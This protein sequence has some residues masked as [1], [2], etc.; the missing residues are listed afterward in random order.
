[1][2]KGVFCYA[3]ASLCIVS[4]M[5]SCDDD[6]DNKLAPGYSGKD[7]SGQV[8]L[9][10]DAE[11][12]KAVLNVSTDNAW[13]LYAGTAED[14]I[15]LSAPYLDGSGKGTFDVDADTKTRS[16]FLF[17]TSEGQG[18][19]A[20]KH[21]PMEGGYNFRD[22]GGIK[23]SEGRFVKWGKIFRTDEMNKLTDEDLAYL[24]ST[25][26]KTVVDF[27]TEAEKKGGMGGMIPEAYDKNPS[28]VE[29]TY[30]LPINAGN[31]FSDEVIGYIS[32]GATAEQLEP[33]MVRTYEEI[34]GVDEYVDMLKQFFTYVQNENCL[35]LSYHCS[36]GKDRTGVATML[37]LSALGVDK[38]T[39]MNDYM[40][41]KECI[42]GKYDRYVAMLP[43]IA[44]LVTVK[45]SY[46]NAAY[47]KITEK[48]GS[49][50]KFLTET[51]QVDIQKMKDLY[52]Y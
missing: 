45:E 25:G 26:L 20:E 41:S 13:Q 37:I 33:I 48:Y 6:D 14:D 3:M 30:E 11:T 51:L 31:I 2:K 24:A 35:P 40:F 12:K 52:L 43:A 34:V 4:V 17:K 1:M 36:A 38:A 46:L 29:K 44:P 5:S 47:D 15:D 9:V 27:R 23:N 19:V 32:G 18:F 50:D 21:L 7:I 8:E 49:V 22:L 16:L 42:A 10:R 28:T 39:I